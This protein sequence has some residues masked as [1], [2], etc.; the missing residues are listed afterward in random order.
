MPFARSSSA[1]ATRR[2]PSASSLNGAPPGS[3][4]VTNHASEPPISPARTRGSR[5][6]R[7]DARLPAAGPGDD[8]DEAAASVIMTE[9]F[10][11]LVDDVVAPEEV[12]RIGLVERAQSLVRVHD[13]VRRRFGVGHGGKERGDDVAD[14]WTVG[15]QE[16]AQR[17]RKVAGCGSDCP[18]PRSGRP[19][20]TWR[21]RVRLDPDP[22]RARP[23]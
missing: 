23:W 19:R 1:T 10:E 20:R 15:G 4:V 8:D 5:P 18:A 16:V 9:P 3:I 21:S 12:G 7:D 17:G 13:T 2:R 14:R 11:Q 6:A 22:P